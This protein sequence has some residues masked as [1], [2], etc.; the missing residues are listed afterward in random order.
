M[1][2]RLTLFPTSPECP[3]QSVSL[4]FQFSDSSR[5]CRAVPVQQELITLGYVLSP[6][7]QELEALAA[8]S[9]VR[10][11][12]R[13][14]RTIITTAGREGSRTRGLKISLRMCHLVHPARDHH[15]ATS[16]SCWP[17]SRCKAFAPL[18]PS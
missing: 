1:K 5:L 17:S 13:V 7:H 8:L 6:G 14:Q 9:P 2:A 12:L 3:R 10:T 16:L 15:P 18:A 4:H 11:L